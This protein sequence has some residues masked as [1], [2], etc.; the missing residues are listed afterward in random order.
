MRSVGELVEKVKIFDAGL[1]DI[2]VEL[3]KY[4]TLRELGR[5][6]PLKFF[7]LDGADGE[8]TFTYPL[9]GEMQMLAV[10][11]NVYEDCSGILQRNPVLREKAAG[12]VAVDATWLAQFMG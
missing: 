2:V 4:V 9:D 7:R 6:V 10:G 8:M 11:L 12:L 1:D 3:C 5:Q